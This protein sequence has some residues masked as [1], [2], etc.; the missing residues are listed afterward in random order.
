M[1]VAINALQGYFL[2]DIGY[3]LGHWGQLGEPTEG[4]GRWPTDAT[5]DVHPVSCYS[6]N[7]YWRS[8]PLYLAIVAGCTGAETDIWFVDDE[9]YIGYRRFALTRNRIF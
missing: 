9:L 7:D 5:G 6:H 1:G 4:F 2:D 3:I 8:V